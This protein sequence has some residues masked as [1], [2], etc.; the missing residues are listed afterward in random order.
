MLSVFPHSNAD[1]ASTENGTIH[2]CIPCM[3]VF[4]PKGQDC[5]F[6]FRGSLASVKEELPLQRR[7]RQLLQKRC[8]D[9]CGWELCLKR[10]TEVEWE[11][12]HATLTC[13]LATP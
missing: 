5:C 13:V 12:K 10:P 7:L 6:R 9:D 1:E 11:L 2:A 4:K 8:G 3:G